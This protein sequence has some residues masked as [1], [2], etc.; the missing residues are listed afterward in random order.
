MYMHIYIQNSNEIGP[1]LGEHVDA[2]VVGIEGH[3][4]FIH[5]CHG[6]VD[7]STNLPNNG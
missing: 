5:I 4:M 6:Q 1:P 7:L 2:S 3:G